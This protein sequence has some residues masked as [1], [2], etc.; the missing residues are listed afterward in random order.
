MRYLLSLT[1]PAILSIAVSAQTPT[2][3]VVNVHLPR[4]ARL[5]VDEVFCPLPGALRSFE[6]P[7]LDIGRRYFYT[8]MVEITVDGKPIRLS[9][10]VDV[11]AGRTTE[12]DFGDRA[13]IVAQAQTVPVPVPPAI[14]E[15][16]VKV[17]QAPP[18]LPALARAEGAFIV[19]TR[20]V[21]EQYLIEEE[22][23][24][25]VDGKPVKIKVAVTKVR[26]KN[27]TEQI[28]ARNVKAIELP[29]TGIASAALATVLAKERS[30]YLCYLDKLDPFYARTLKPGTIILFVPAGEPV[31]P[32]R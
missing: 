21:F 6:T 20:P 27:I 11:Q 29:N 12:V 30:V 19:I 26:S 15:G 13:L 16:P 18:P 24:R 1:L 22:R 2:T 3:G 23:I 28:D 4:D 25:E 17:P 9:K 31:N 7:P 14:E 8:L 10:R 32:G 5:Y